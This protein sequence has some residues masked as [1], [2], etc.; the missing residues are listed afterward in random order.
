MRCSLLWAIALIFTVGCGSIVSTPSTA[1]SAAPSA[2]PSA[3]ATQS[4]AA[5]PTASPT[6]SSEI[7]T[8][9]PRARATPA[10]LTPTI[11]L[12]KPFQLQPN[13]S[14]LFKTG[15]LTVKFL[16][17]KQDSRC[18]Q[19]TM[20]AWA[21]QASIQ[22]VISQ[23]GRAGAPVTLTRSLGNAAA[24]SHALPGYRLQFLDL[25]PY[26]TAPG[27]GQPV[28]AYTASFSLSRLPAQGQR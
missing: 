25:A 24:A 27:P 11:T 28:P 2:A 19:G 14:A 13:Q 6:G 15:Q 26:P 4:P 10:T 23:K 5:L 16:N 20:C 21:G 9:P 22:V 3:A 18:P 12:N 17:V 7:A 1:S 8:F